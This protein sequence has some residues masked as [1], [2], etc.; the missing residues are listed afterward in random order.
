[1]SIKR[2]D[3]LMD[4]SPE[5]LLHISRYVRVSVTNFIDWNCH[6]MF[7]FCR[8]KKAEEFDKLKKDL[9]RARR[10]DMNRI[11]K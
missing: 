4:N 2:V 7:V 8:Q 9:T 6:L 1:M 10:N 3:E 5:K 11:W